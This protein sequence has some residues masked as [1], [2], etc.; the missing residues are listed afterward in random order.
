MGV[1]YI[2]MLNGISLTDK[3]A[4]PGYGRPP[5]NYGAPP[6][7][8]P[9]GM[10]PPGMAPPGMGPPGMGKWLSSF[11][12]SKYYLIL[13]YLTHFEAPVFLLSRL[14]SLHQVLSPKLLL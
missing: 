1:S 3:H 9:P 13:R 10:P 14:V 6:G 7:M 2:Q 8:V 4:A 5:S 12:H 11:H